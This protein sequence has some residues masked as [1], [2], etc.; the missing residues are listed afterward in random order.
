M[1]SKT[2]ALHRNH[3]YADRPVWVTGILL[4][5]WMISSV[6][7]TVTNKTLMT[8]FPYSA[9]LTLVQIT[10][11][12][13]VD[14]I[15][16]LY[17]RLS[18]LPLN[19]PLLIQTLPVAASINFS[20][21]LTYVSYGY[22]P[23]S[24]THT[25]KASSPIFSVALSKLL[26]NKAPSMYIVLSLIPITVGVT[27]SALTELNFAL[28][29]FIA[30][31]AASVAAVLN[32][33]YGKQ[34]LHH[35]SC[36][37]PIIFHFYTSVCAVLMVLPWVLYNDLYSIYMS[38]H[39]TTS[40]INVDGIT[41]I[42]T[43]GIPYQLIILSLAMHY[44]Q[45]ISSIYYLAGVTVLTHQVASTMKRLMV[46]AST[47]VYFGNPVGKSKSYY[48]CVVVVVLIGG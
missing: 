25:A 21:T 13:V 16:I 43:R 36:P 28:F 2:A 10:A 47:V 29:G 12:C 7:S 14:Y 42:I 24:L 3:H 15:I 37:D 17:R 27:L 1:G 46:I 32:S 40:I 38:V 30:A 5:V 22:V 39:T 6:A 4:F 19:R 8:I 41:S 20:K 26:Y 31:V 33:I 23:A 34:A 9:T 48:L 45:N 11:S 35:I 18:I 44:L